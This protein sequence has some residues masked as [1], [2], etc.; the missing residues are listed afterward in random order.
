MASLSLKNIY[1]VYPNGF[2]A[3]MD[4]NLEIEDKEFIIFV[5]P[6]GCG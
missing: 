1:K 5:G 3:V 4:F 2:N 6:S